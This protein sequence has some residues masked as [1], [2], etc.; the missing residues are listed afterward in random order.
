MTK[1]TKEKNLGLNDVINVE[2]NEGNFYISFEKDLNLYFSYLG[3]KLE[4]KDEYSFTIDKENAFLYE[5]FDEL[6]N[7]VESEKPFK[8]SDNLPDKDYLYPLSNTCVE[9]DHGCGIIEWHSDDEADYDSAS[10]LEIMPYIDSYIVTFKKSKSKVGHS[11]YSVCI[12]NGGSKYDPYNISFM[13]MYNKL[14]EH[15]FELDNN[16]LEEGYSRTR[17][18]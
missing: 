2:T 4:D 3:S 5:C 17:K 18:R 11:A 14:H 7:S 8:Y 6:Y 12:K 10:V 13:I 9:L 1:V 15:N 16:V